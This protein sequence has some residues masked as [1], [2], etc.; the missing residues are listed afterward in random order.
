V[1]HVM[2]VGRLKVIKK[3]ISNVCIVKK[4]CKRIHFTKNM[5]NKA[6]YIYRNNR[7]KKEVNI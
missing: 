5:Y 6:L 7:F 2:L 1:C 4:S 3:L